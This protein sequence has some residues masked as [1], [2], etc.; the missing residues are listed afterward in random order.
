MHAELHLIWYVLKNTFINKKPYLTQFV[1]E[2][3]EKQNEAD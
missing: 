1:P 2:M 3:R